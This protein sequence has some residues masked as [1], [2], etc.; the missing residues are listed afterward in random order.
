MEHTFNDIEDFLTNESFRNWVNSP[1]PELDAQWTSWM[2]A[3]QGNQA[4][5]DLA[6]QSREIIQSLHFKKFQADSGAKERIFQ[7][8]QLKTKPTRQYR[9]RWDARYK[10]AAVLILALSI[11]A[12]L[13]FYAAEK[14]SQ[15]TI[16]VVSNLVQKT[17]PLGV[18]S[19]HILP[20]GST[21]FLNAASSI[22]YPK[23]FGTDTRVVKLLQGE[24]FFEVVKDVN[25]PFR[26]LGKDFDVEVLGTTFNINTHLPS[27][28]VALL[29]GKVRLTAR[30]TGH[31][32][33]LAPGQMA[34]FDKDQQVFTSSTFDAKY[35]TGWKDGY[36]MFKDATLDEVMEKLHVWYGID[37][38]VS[39]KAKSGDWSYTGSFKNE[40][41]ENVLLNMRVLRNFNYAIKND[42]LLISF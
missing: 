11:G 38:T 8:I 32:T 29:E 22:E 25:R 13:R 10:I 1:T 37:I 9:I 35:T 40:S 14:P 33:D 42:S 5:I 27:P 3:N 20:D 17:N 24:A 19:K 31:S 2:E 16:S 26:V 15:E 23:T 36:L 6:N 28:E 30:Q 39:N 18:K 7:K 41:L 21:V 34:L 12:L 4:K